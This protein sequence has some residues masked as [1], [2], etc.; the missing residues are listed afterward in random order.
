MI[1]SFVREKFDKH[2]KDSFSKKYLGDSMGDDDRK[3]AM[4]M[5]LN[6]ERKHLCV[7]GLIKEFKDIKMDNLL[8]NKSNQDARDKLDGLIKDYAIM[9]IHA[10]LRIKLEEVK[11]ISSLVQGSRND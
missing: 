8:K 11:G 9:F 3:S 1:D 10:A 5:I 2:V 6:H 4:D 7:N